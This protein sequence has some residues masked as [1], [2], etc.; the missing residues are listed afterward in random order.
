MAL[1]SHHLCSQV[2]LTFHLCQ[3]RD[4]QVSLERCFQNWYNQPLKHLL[5]YSW[6]QARS[7]PSL[8]TFCQSGLVPMLCLVY[9]AVYIKSSDITHVE[10]HL[11]AS[12]SRM[13]GLTSGKKEASFKSSLSGLHCDQRSNKIYRQSYAHP[14]DLAHLSSIDR[15]D[16]WF[17]V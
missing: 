1:N 6:A 5:P 11:H 16:F 7:S 10:K 17:F 9:A 13:K 8:L 3:L 12:S 2:A 4:T 14:K 15:V